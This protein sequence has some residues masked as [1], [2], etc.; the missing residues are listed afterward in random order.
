MRARKLS[1]SICSTLIWA[2]MWNTSFYTNLIPSYFFPFHHIHNELKCKHADLFLSSSFGFL[3]LSM[4]FRCKRIVEITTLTMFI[5]KEMQFNITA[6]FISPHKVVQEIT[7]IYKLWQMFYIFWHILN[8]EYIYH[9]T[10][11]LITPSCLKYNFFFTCCFGL[12]EIADE[13]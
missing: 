3:Q 2:K 13:M 11:L 8:P 9:D 5:R 12:R 10:Y 1:F 6:K 7:W 4:I